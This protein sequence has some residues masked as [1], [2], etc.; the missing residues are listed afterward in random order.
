MSQITRLR[1]EIDE[2]DREIVKQLNRRIELVLKAGEYKRNNKLAVED[3]AREEEIISKMEF[4]ELDEK[5][6]KDIYKVILGYSKLKQRS[7]SGNIQST[8]KYD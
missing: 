4:N 1:K 7:Q 6:V 8:D 3:L 5:F 2:I